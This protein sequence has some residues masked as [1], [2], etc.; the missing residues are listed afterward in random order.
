MEAYWKECSN[1]EKKEVWDWDSLLEWDVVAAKAKSAGYGWL[2]LA[3]VG[4]GWCVAAVG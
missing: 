1:L 3:A 2:S 4:C